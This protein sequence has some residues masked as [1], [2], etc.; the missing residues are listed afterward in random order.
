[1]GNRKYL[2]NVCFQPK[3]HDNRAQKNCGGREVKGVGEVVWPATARN[4][5]VGQFEPHRGI[6]LASFL[7]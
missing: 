3:E 7:V 2:E 5:P 6:H 1:M 4:E